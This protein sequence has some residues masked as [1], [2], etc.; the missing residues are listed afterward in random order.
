MVDVVNAVANINTAMTN[1]TE[2]SLT[3]DNYADAGITGVTDDNLAA[4][5]K[6][7]EGVTPTLTAAQIQDLVDGVNDAN[8]E[9]L[10]E[11]TEDI[12]GNTNGTPATSDQINAIFGVSGAMDGVDYSEVL[13]NGTYVDPINPTAEEIQ[14]AVDIKNYALDHPDI[15]VKNTT[16]V[17]VVQELIRLNILVKIQKL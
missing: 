8:T 9:G 10:A 3:K 15:Q 14:A 16:T 17:V 6:A 4:V 2:S 5:N 1:D 13:K 7:L 11:V 12:A